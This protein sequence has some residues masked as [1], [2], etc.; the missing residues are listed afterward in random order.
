M[1]QITISNTIIVVRREMS[2]YEFL[3]KQLEEKCLPIIKDRDIEIKICICRKTNTPR[4]L[5]ICFPIPLDMEEIKK[6]V[7]SS[8]KC[9]RFSLKK[10]TDDITSSSIFLDY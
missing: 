9:T 3:L 5:I 10:I 2:D 1:E 4:I 6:L 8:L 7:V